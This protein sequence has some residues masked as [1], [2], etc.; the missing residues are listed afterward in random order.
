MLHHFSKALVCIT[1][2]REVEGPDKAEATE[3][4]QHAAEASQGCSNGAMAAEGVQAHHADGVAPLQ[5]G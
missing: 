5:A 4:Q 3:A 1:A 2:A